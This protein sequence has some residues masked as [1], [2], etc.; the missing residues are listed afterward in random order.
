MRAAGH[1]AW[2][3]VLQIGASTAAVLCLLC[4]GAAVSA[5]IDRVAR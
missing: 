1:T 2:T 5:L 4:V 3:V